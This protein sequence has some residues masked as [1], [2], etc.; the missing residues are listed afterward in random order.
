M[1]LETFNLRFGL[2][3]LIAYYSRCRS[4]ILF[5]ASVC[6]CNPSTSWSYVPSSP[7]PIFVAQPLSW[8]PSNFHPHPCPFFPTLSLSLP[9]STIPLFPNMFCSSPTSPC[10]VPSS[11]RTSSP[12][13]SS[14]SASPQESS[15]ASSMW[16]SCA[17]L[18]SSAPCFRLQIQSPSNIPFQVV[19]FSFEV[20]SLAASS[21]WLSS[22]FV[23]I[24]PVRY[25]LVED[26]DTDLLSTFV[27]SFSLFRFNVPIELLLSNS[28]LSV[29]RSERV[30]VSI[31]FAEKESAGYLS[32][33]HSFSRLF[34]W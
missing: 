30:V 17:P 4:R 5:S 27:S 16:Q 12:Q 24:L 18:Q 20:L 23:V 2:V 21:F 13:A 19:F 28:S 11:E 34:N 6:S 32:L 14:N 33:L 22:I 3:W 25:V 15:P 29:L 26:G 8:S 10:N 31:I 1:G 7:Y 9:H